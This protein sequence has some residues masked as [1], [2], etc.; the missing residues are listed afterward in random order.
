MPFLP[1]IFTRLL[2]T[3]GP[4][5]ILAT[6]LVE[7]YKKEYGAITET[8]KENLQ[9]WYNKDKGQSTISDLISLLEKA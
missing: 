3:F 1:I 9:M 7:D 8:L 2:G 6:A 5:P 4:R